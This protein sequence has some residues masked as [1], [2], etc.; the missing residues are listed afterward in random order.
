MLQADLEV[1][2]RPR[3]FYGDLTDQALRNEPFSDT[4]LIA[5]L[6]DP[7]IELFSLLN[8]AYAVRLAN[9]GKA[10]QV[11]ILNNAQNG[12]CPEDCSYCTQAKTSEA[13]I[14]P[15]AMKPA[16]EVLAEA[17]RA[18]HAG[19]H[20]YCMVFSGR[21]PSEKRTEQLAGLVREIKTKYPSLEVC[22]SAGLL[23]EPKAQKLA[24]AGLDRLN[25]NLNTSRDRY[26]TICTTHTYDDRV[27]TLRAAQKAGLAKCS[28]LIVGMGE[29]PEEVV[30]VAR[31]LREIGADSIPVNFLLPFEGNAMNVPH[32]GGS[33]GEKTS[34]GLTPE[35]CLR[36]LCMFRLCCPTSEVR[37]AAG[38]EFHLR[39]LEPMCLYPAN[40]LF[41]DGYL[42]GM[43]AERRRTY[44]MIRDAG[45]EIQSD[46]DVDALLEELPGDTDPATRSAL[47]ID[48]VGFDGQP[49]IKD[50]QQ[51]R[52][53]QK[54]KH[55]EPRPTR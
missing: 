34:G 3:S 35:Y 4:E 50:L 37:C 30:E 24:D 16:E 11:H 36:V 18:Y 40:S 22:V 21:G 2:T 41:L 26:G 55:R 28:G 15:Y 54:P 5:L 49:A 39:S 10:V 51:L 25:H 46:H 6:T 9:F 20:R 8:A 12:R 53:S 14:E 33:H 38:R 23:D 17:E 32:I 45:F 47:T 42:N 19:A 31:T 7:S 48:G 44:A 13:G 43:G 27:N 1:M 29:P 52:P